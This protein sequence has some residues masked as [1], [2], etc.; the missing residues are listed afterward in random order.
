MSIDAV[1]VDIDEEDDF[2][3]LYICALMMMS[4]DTEEGLLIAH[5]ECVSMRDQM[6]FINDETDDPTLGS[7][8]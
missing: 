7:I 2:K 6:D 3:S 1:K 4:G 5:S 8:H